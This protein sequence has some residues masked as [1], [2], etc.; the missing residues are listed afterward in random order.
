M[1]RAVEAQKRYATQ[2]PPTQSEP[3]ASLC[4][5]SLCGGDDPGDRINAGVFVLAY[6]R[7][8]R[9]TRV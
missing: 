3:G 2:K 6:D 7:P 4:R 1:G 5:A 9:W 8:P